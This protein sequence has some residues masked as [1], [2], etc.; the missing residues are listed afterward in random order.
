MV[1]R[2][3][4]ALCCS[5]LAALAFAGC[6][7]Q[8]PLEL[9]CMDR[10]DM[11]RYVIGCWAW[12]GARPAGQPQYDEA[13]VRQLAADGFTAL[14]GGMGDLH[15]QNY[16]M[17][18]TGPI[19]NDPPFDIDLLDKY[20]LRYMFGCYHTRA[21]R[22]LALHK[23]WG[24]G[25]RVMG[26]QLND[27]CDLHSYT[28]TSA[29]LLKQFAP[30]KVRWVSTNPN[31][32][33]QSRLNQPIISTQ[34]YPFAW[35]PND[36]EEKI[37]RE[38]CDIAENDRF[39]ANSYGMAPW[40]VV[41][42]AGVTPSQYRFQVTTAAAYGAQGVW[43]FTYTP[44]MK[45]AFSRVFV[46]THRYLADVAGPW[47][48]GRRSVAVLHTGPEIPAGHRQ[49][50]PGELIEKMDD[51]LL[52]GVLVPDADFQAGR[53]APDCIYVVD[54]RTAKSD[55]AKELQRKRFGVK[56][57]NDTPPEWAAKLIE[58][59]HREDP[60]PRSVRLT[61]SNKVR[62]AVA[63]LPGGRVRPYDLTRGRE[64]ELPPTRGGEAVLLRI[65]ARPVK[66][67]RI[68]ADAAIRALPRNWKFRFDTKNVAERERWSAPGFDD[69]RWSELRVPAYCG[70]KYQQYN[71][72]GKVRECGVVVGNG[73]YR[74][75]LAVP[76]EWRGKHIYLHFG[77]AD[78]QTWVY[79]D[80]K[81][82]L[83]NTSKATGYSYGQLWKLPFHTEVT[84]VFKDGKEHTLAVRVHNAGGAGGLYEPVYLIASDEPLDAGQLWR[85]A[86]RETR[87]NESLYE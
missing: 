18:V 65:D 17:K 32:I 60:A 63:L 26:Y 14:V 10:F 55:A 86:I 12:H 50:G 51:H 35:H 81:L 21:P 47:L 83:E 31:P 64:I 39:V 70:W 56:H 5:V 76:P 29:A 42:S 19:L 25:R 68:P 75:R 7:R 37:R 11:D 54:K 6:A 41:I 69:G 66:V 9:A 27:N 85:L 33:P 22:L 67:I 62:S 57:E 78:E 8:K 84:D 48:L 87:A 38:F 79:A 43:G 34:N 2:A 20:N 4:R 61:L 71:F 77:A 46:P 24:R 13:Y 53:I 49:P 82:I 28:Y 73:W 40:A 1:S 15:F 23:K 72:D 80:G 45:H 44:L 3:S 58:K 59:M 52:A 74:L 36:P 30:D 16:L